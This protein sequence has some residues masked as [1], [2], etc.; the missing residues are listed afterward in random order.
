[1][2]TPV[3]VSPGS[4]AMATM[5]SI[6][7]ASSRAFSAIVKKQLAA[8]DRQYLWLSNRMH[9]SQSA[10]EFKCKQQHRQWLHRDGAVRRLGQTI[11]LLL[12]QQSKMRAMTH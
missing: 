8:L 11:V 3:H 2:F 1:M 5:L 9:E 7:A 10:T 4:V 12:Q 6:P